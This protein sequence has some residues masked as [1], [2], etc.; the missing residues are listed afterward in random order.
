VEQDPFRPERSRPAVRFRSSQERLAA[1]ATALAPSGMPLLAAPAPDL[2]RLVGTMVL[3]NGR[4]VAL[5]ELTGQSPR[6][7][8]PG[9]RIGDY[10][11]E[12][13]GRRSATLRSPR[14]GVIELHV[15]SPGS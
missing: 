8:R 3:A 11:L 1:A 7:L 5:C 6:L 15:P 13:V 12:R 10:V 2:P 4:A 14:T 9:D